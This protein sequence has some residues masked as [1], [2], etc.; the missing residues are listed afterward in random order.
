[1]SKRQFLDSFRHVPRVAVNLLITG[2]RGEFLLTKRAISPRKGTWHLP[3]SFL[4][5]KESLKECILRVAKEELGIEIEKESVKLLGV[6]EDIDKDPRGHVIDLVY[7]Y[8]VGRK[9]DF[10]LGKGTKEVKFFA[11]IP[12]KIGFTHGEV[13]R[14]LGYEYTYLKVKL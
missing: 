7:S 8:K 11:K 13:L 1:M 4:M 12:G 6:Y 10:E 9:V 14:E 3:G 2:K 5:K